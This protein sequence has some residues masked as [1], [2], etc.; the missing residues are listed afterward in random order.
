MIP[1]PNR[2]TVG[3][4]IAEETNALPDEERKSGVRD[5]RHDDQ[6]RA[7]RERGEQRR[8]SKQRYGSLP[9]LGIPPCSRGTARC[10]SMVVAT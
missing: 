2:V 3:S 1:A 8:V 7:Q 4:P 6:E 10:R 5:G 9:P